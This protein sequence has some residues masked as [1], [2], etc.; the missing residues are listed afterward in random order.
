MT[1]EILPRVDLSFRLAATL[2]PLDHGYAL[3]GGL[4]RILGDLH[5]APWLAVHP[6]SGTPR[7][8]GLLALNAH[9]GLRLRLD[10]AQIP[11]VL[12][13]AGKSMELDGHVLRIGVPTIGA[14]QPAPALAARLVVIKGFAEPEPFR[15]AVRRQLEAMAVQ[16]RVE[17]GRR[18]VVRIGGD[19]V[20]GFGVTLHD[21]SE[22][23]SLRVQYAGVGGR[24]R[25]G[26][27]IFDPMRQRRA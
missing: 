19:T 1:Q 4:C 5:G 8:D 13:L 12:P 11:R 22:E 23:G 27:G 24:Q 3:F 6:L 16:A 15:E 18:R 10:P 26:C 2:A 7:P 14:L 20:V 17:V 21:L 25:M 9:R